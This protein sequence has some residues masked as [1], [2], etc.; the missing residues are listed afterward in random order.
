MD[1]PRDDDDPSAN[2][3]LEL[4][5]TAANYE[6]IVSYVEKGDA[7]NPLDNTTETTAAKTVQPGQSLDFQETEEKQQ[8][9]AENE[10]MQE[11]SRREGDDSDIQ[12][13]SEEEEDT[14]RTGT[15]ETSSAEEEPAER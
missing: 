4:D 5:E 1:D 12:N 9:D 15:G 11:T 13:M 8:G 10:E 6:E 3:S 14:Q 7:A 2:E